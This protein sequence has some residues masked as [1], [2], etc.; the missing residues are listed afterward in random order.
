M[1][2]LLSGLV[3]GLALLGALPA[4]AQDAAAAADMATLVADSVQAKGADTL[5]AA[6]NVEVLYKGSR[7]RATRVTYDQKANRL[8]IEGPL[9][10]IGADGHTTLL[11]DSADLSADLTEGV[12]RSARMVLD[13]KLQIAATRIDRVGGRYTQLTQTVTSSC[14]VC[15]AH[16]V[17][18]W[19]I[20]ARRVV[21]D[22]LKQQIY[23]EDAQ[24][25]FAGVPVFYLPSMRLPDPTVQRARGFLIPNL[26]S[27][28]N[29]GTALKLPYFIPLGPS[30]D[31]TLTPF[32]GSKSTR[33]LSLRYR[34]SF[35]TGAI[36][37]DGATSRDG[38]LPGKN[39]GYLFG[40]GNFKL[41]QG[42]NL[43]FQVQTVSDPDYFVNYGL[44][45]VDRLETGV[46][47]SRASRDE[48]IDGR[49]LHFHSIRSGDDNATLPN[50]VGTFDWV[51]RYQ[52]G[53]IGGTATLSFRSMALVRA[54]SDPI[55]GRDVTRAGVVADWRRSWVLPYGI[56]GTAA[57]AVQSDIYRVSQD[58]TYG[59]P[60]TRT[61]PQAALELR[62]PWVRAGRDGAAQVIEPVV[63]L[64]WSPK[65]VTGVPNED[66][67]L[68]EFDEGNLWSLNHFSGVDGTE[69]GA[70]ANVGVSWT[71]YAASGW[72]FGVT[73]GR[74][75][76]QVSATS[77]DPASGL[78]GASS[79]WLVAGQLRWNGIDLI[80][81]SVFDNNGLSKEELRLN[82][83]RDRYS[84]GTSYL[85][86]VAD[87]TALSTSTQPTREWILDAGYPIRRNWSGKIAW[88]YD[89][90]AKRADATG[91]SFAW[92]NECISVDLSLS[93]LYSSSTSVS[94]NT[95]IGFS[96]GLIGFG[97]TS[98]SAAG[99]SQC[100]K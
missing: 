46:E 72:S 10:L 18:L 61:L 55:D 94:P 38:L 79:D 7:L 24:L 27:S 21:H 34:Q 26:Y 70:R 42:F 44:T 68:N 17:P 74:I 48:Y 62:W 16:P 66:S 23:F 100:V 85:W 65:S 57:A 13:Q 54:S 51:R 14:Q 73:A 90:V 56:V 98:G 97:G 39:R 9:T 19:E 30:R 78:A 99:Q 45:Q 86:M 6:G 89:F 69:T 37:F 8:S 41:P 96:V 35:N 47:I 15:A 92:R 28:S 53:L 81:R 2:R 33:S 58:P 52:P 22:Q 29:F 71:R 31:L 95:T 25:R 91:V 64:I 67:Q 75:F 63:Q 3:L 4:A 49:V 59:S 40:S 12:L 5:V 50:N 43:Q 93:R 36:E 32:I 76:R 11:A 80:N 84:L 1:R 83:T 20:R 87:P 60:L 88:R 82:W 77:F